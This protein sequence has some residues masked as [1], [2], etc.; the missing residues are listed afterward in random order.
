MQRAKSGRILSPGASIP[1]E[2]GCVLLS[3]WMHPATWKLS[4]PH[5]YQVL[6]RL[7]Q[8]GMTN[9]Y[10]I[11]VPVPLPSLE[12][13]GVGQKIPSFELGL[14]LPGELPLCRSQAGAHPKS[15]YENKRCSCYSYHIGIYEFHELFARRQRP[16]YSFSVIVIFMWAFS[17]VN[18]GLCFVF[19]FKNEAV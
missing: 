1:M 8:L 18:F 6:W 11:P 5:A 4:K 2:L 10:I 19:I 12:V 13:G 3:V 17:K 14:G 7:P 9:Y 16:I 15:Y